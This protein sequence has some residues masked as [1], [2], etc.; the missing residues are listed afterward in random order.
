MKSRLTASILLCLSLLGVFVA[1]PLTVRGVSASVVISE[2]RVRGPNGGSDEFI[3]LYNLSSG[4]VDVSGWKIRGSNASGSVSTRATIP[5]GTMIPPGCYYLLTNRSTS[6]GP[7]SGAVPGDIT[8]ATGITDDG[9]LALTLPDDS[10]V[11]QVGLSAGSAF[12]EGTRLASLGGSNLDRGYERLPGGA[13][14]ATQDT[15]NNAGDFQLIAPSTP[16]NSTSQ[17]AGGG[18]TDPSGVGASSPSSVDPGDSTLLTVAVT[19]GSNPTSTGLAVTADLSAIGGSA[20][21]VFFDDGSNGDVTAG[22]DT[23]SFLATV[24]SGGAVGSLSLPATISDAEGRSGSANIP[25]TVLPPLM[26]IHTI[27]G[28]GNASPFAGQLVRTSGIVTAHKSNGFFAQTPDNAVDGDANTSEG[29]FVFTMVSPPMAAAVGNEVE[30][31]GFVSEFVPGADPV[32]PPIT[33]LT[34]ASVTVLST[35]NALPLPMTITAADTSPV[36]PIEQLERYEFMRVLVA[37]LE[38]I[39]PSQG[40]VNETQATG[41]NNGVFY[42]VVSGVAR[43]FREPGIDALDPLPGG[44][45]CCIPRFDGNPERLRVDSDGQTGGAALVVTSGATLANVT[46]VL[47]FGFRTYTLLPDPATPPAVSGLAVAGAV[48]QPGINE[49]TVGSMNLQRLF[50]TVNDPMISDPVPTATA[51]DRRLGKISMAIRNVM[52]APEII[53][54]QEVENLATLQALADRINNDEMT[55]SGTNPLYVPYLQE[56]NDPGGIDVG[57]LV[58]ST[59]VTVTNVT[60]EGLSATYTDPNTGLPATLNDRPP[61]VMEATVHSTIGSSLPVTVIV[62]HLRSFIDIADPADGNRVRTKRNAQAEF[63]ANLVQ[64]RQAANPDERI[65]LVGDFN[66]FQFNDGYADVMGTVK[67]APAPANEVVLASTD[68]VNPDLTNLV[69]GVPAVQ[70]YSY[71]FDG[72]AQVLDHIL[73][74]ASLAP[75][76]S[77]MHYARNNADFPEAYRSDGARPERY[78]DHDMPVAYFALEPLTVPINIRPHAF[79]NVIRL[80]ITAELLPVAILAKT[81]FDPA[82]IDPS[83]ITLAGAPA[84]PAPGLTFHDGLVDVNGD[85]RTDLVVY[86]SM[87][88]LLL[89]PGDTSAVLHALTASGL[90]VRGADSVVVQP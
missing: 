15:D 51:F 63:L 71:S 87:P 54:V 69:N 21:Q 41:S 52:R 57:F 74:T 53:G 2:F 38:A 59:R 19:P 49:F 22:D 11:D 10:P 29:V 8:Y 76:F 44:S 55:A 40:S 23:F 84:M 9:G 48:P 7:Y 90:H 67:G 33:E 35:G 68:L 86:F 78:S 66:A 6:G 36:G 62:N 88:A 3:E 39:S 1:V 81:N 58:K 42:A 65:I 77:R 83:T 28:A 25:L 13:S 24:G 80:S 72:H 47:D 31:T 73:H 32:S 85:G 75:R 46:G 5:A 34:G 27:Q 61:L 16:Q 14:G 45:P 17:C 4:T 70:R 50:D 56:G 18:P 60:Q 82:T 43:P 12:G 20:V 37:S 89:Q 79:P 26:A 30:L 64:A